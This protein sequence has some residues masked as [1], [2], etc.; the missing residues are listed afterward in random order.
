MLFFTPNGLPYAGKTLSGR[1]TRQN[2][3][4]KN[5]LFYLLLISVHFMTVNAQ[6]LVPNPSFENLERCPAPYGGWPIDLSR[7]VS[8]WYTA[9]CGS[10]D[11][12]SN[13]GNSTPVGTR[14]DAPNALFF[15]VQHARTGTN[16]VDVGHYGFNDYIG[17]RL[18]EPLEANEAYQVKFYVSCAD[19]VRYATDNIGLYFS[20]TEIKYQKLNGTSQANGM[21]LDGNHFLYTPQIRSTPGVFLT[22]YENWVEVSGVYVASGGE[23][24]ITIGCFFPF[25]ASHASVFDFGVGKVAD[26]NYTGNSNARIVFFIDD[27]SVE[28]ISLLP[29]KLLSFEGKN[30]TDGV[31]LDWKTVS[32]INNC[33][34]E[35]Q[36]GEHPGNFTTIGTI[37]GA[38]NSTALEEYTFTDAHPLSTTAYYRL[39]QVDCDGKFEYSKI[40]SIEGE[41]PRM[42]IHPNPVHDKIR[43]NWDKP[44]T[45][46]V[47]IWNT[48]GQE[49]ISPKKFSEQAFDIEVSGLNPGIYL[50]KAVH[51]G[52]SYTEK[53]IKR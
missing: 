16:Y 1:K 47:S 3:R 10:P 12:I 23:E 9:N 6:N 18:I 30:T 26:P 4:Q 11:L 53:I 34:F 27:I 51:N 22:D 50:L 7:N 42:I 14:T 48:A 38:I 2:K 41:A 35:I 31:H 46:E 40:I 37:E 20:T 43:L 19:Y 5:L 44:G 21:C 24:Y 17:T 45:F 15:G 8:H 39:K 13:C 32:E 25:S 28:K 33:H 52:H 29:I 36:R 49:V